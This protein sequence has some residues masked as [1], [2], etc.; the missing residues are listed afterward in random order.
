MRL[1]CR[2]GAGS[3]AHRRA[4][5]SA[6]RRRVM[7]RPRGRDSGTRRRPSPVVA[8]ADRRTCR[9]VA[10]RMAARPRCRVRV[11]KR[12]ASA[13][14]RDRAASALRRPVRPARTCRTADRLE[15]RAVDR[16][17]VRRRC[18]RTA[19]SA[20]VVVVA[21]VVRRRMPVPV[22]RRFPVRRMAARR[23]CQAV[24]ETFRTVDRRACPVVVRPRRTRRSEDRRRCRVRVVRR[25][26][27]RRRC[28]GRAERDR[29]AMTRA[30]SIAAGRP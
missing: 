19:C 15:C 7:Q 14:C 16:A 6:H 12:R 5:A 29:R 8:S 27:D 21:L 22:A 26:V 10:D 25:L 1:R 3:A 23:R 9:R 28:P 11:H 13:G 4:L 30:C 20:A 24:A 18:H 17:K 2:V